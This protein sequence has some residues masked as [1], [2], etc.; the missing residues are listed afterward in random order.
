MFGNILL[1]VS[2]SMKDISVGDAA[3]TAVFGYSVVCSINN[4]FYK[5]GDKNERNC[6]LRFCVVFNIIHFCF[7]HT[8]VGIKRNKSGIRCYF[9]Y[10]RQI[11]FA[12][13]SGFYASFGKY[14]R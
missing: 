7:M 6:R 1:A 10:P 4:N 12:I 9:W 2:E 5:R 11:L 8:R 3:V 13:A 14:S